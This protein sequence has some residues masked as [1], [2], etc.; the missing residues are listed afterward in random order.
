VYTCIV[1]FLYNFL[2]TLY[3]CCY[4]GTAGKD[5]TSITL[6]LSGD[7]SKLK[8]TDDS[9]I[10]TV[11][12]LGGDKADFVMLINCHGGDGGCG[13]PGG[14]GGTGG[15]G[16]DG[17]K[18]A[19]DGDGGHG[20]DGGL[21]GNGANGAPGGDA[22]NGG[23]CIIQ[24][25]D[26]RLLM[27]VEVNCEAGRA[28]LGGEPGTA[29]EGGSR[30]FGGD[31]GDPVGVPPGSSDCVVGLRGKPG[32]TGSSGM[33]GRQGESGTSGFNGGILWVIQSTDGQ[34]QY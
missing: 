32:M 19:P 16:G 34:S 12:K 10:S 5:G 29:G 17:G 2:C 26:A 8:V 14:N 4:L 20:G 31:A 21:G 3:I 13:G 33:D 1:V 6:T 15:T 25:T 18:G 9:S 7:A 27:L 30:G 28:G 11:A 22:G 24:A 23:D